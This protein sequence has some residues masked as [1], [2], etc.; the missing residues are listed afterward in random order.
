MSC[1]ITYMKEGY[2]LGF[3]TDEKICHSL[4]MF[5]NSSDYL[6]LSNSLYSYVRQI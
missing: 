5:L 1:I 4:S 2:G 3:V 6:T